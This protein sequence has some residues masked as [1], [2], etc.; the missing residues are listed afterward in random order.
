MIVINWHL[1]YTGGSLH[2][3]VNK[4]DT[5]TVSAEASVSG[6][7]T[8]ALLECVNLLDS[9]RITVLERSLLECYTIVMLKE[10]HCFIINVALT[11]TPSSSYL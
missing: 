2:S 7:S 3:S 5:K 10:V 8:K 1:I 6:I 9:P 11:L 4:D